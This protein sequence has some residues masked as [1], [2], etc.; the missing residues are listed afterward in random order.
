MLASPV[1]YDR[2]AVSSGSMFFVFLKHLN[3]RNLALVLFVA[4]ALLTPTR[5]EDP[6]RTGAV[7]KNAA[8]TGVTIHDFGCLPD[9]DATG[10]SRHHLF[11]TGA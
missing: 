11:S 8:K 2:N 10:H 5:A 6:E 3:A 9:V 1:C 4:L 7:P